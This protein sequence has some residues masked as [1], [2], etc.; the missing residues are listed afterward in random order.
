LSTETGSGMICRIRWGIAV[1]KIGP[2][3]GCWYY[4]CEDSESS[5]RQL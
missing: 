2:S 1:R 3:L 5:F 4:D